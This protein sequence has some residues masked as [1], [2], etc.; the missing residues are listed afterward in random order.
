MDCRSK[1]L[2]RQRAEVVIFSSGDVRV[3]KHFTGRSRLHCCTQKVHVND[4]QSAAS[5][6]SLCSFFTSYLV[7]VSF[8][9][10]VVPPP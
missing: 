8:T 3:S 6:F 10:A 4:S 1:A 7:S 5:L 9:T 2:K